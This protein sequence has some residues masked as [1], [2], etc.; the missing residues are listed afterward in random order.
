MIFYRLSHP[1]PYDL[2]QQH[3]YFAT[4]K[5]AVDYCIQN[6]YPTNERQIEK[7]SVTLKKR[8]LISEFNFCAVLG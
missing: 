7:C 2:D 1:M 8:D 6:E 4:K 3:E 5:E